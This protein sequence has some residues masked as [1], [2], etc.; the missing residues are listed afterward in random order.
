MRPLLASALFSSVLFPAIAAAAPPTA[1]RIG[2]VEYAAVSKSSIDLECSACSPSRYSFGKAY[3]DGTL[4]GTRT[5][6]RDLGSG[7]S[8]RGIDASNLYF[9]DSS[10]ALMSLD[11]STPQKAES[12]P[13]VAAAPHPFTS[14]IT[15]ASSEPFSLFAGVSGGMMEVFRKEPL[16]APVL[17]FSARTTEA[18]FFGRF[19]R[20][21]PTA[22]SPRW[23]VWSSRSLYATDGTA[24]GT[25]Q[26]ADG[27]IECDETV[28]PGERDVIACRTNGMYLVDGATRTLV[29]A[30]LYVSD[31]LTLTKVS[32]APAAGVL[33]VDRRGGA[34]V[35]GS[36]VGFDLRYSAPNGTV[37]VLASA[38]P[39]VSR[40]IVRDGR[41]F[42]VRGGNEP[43]VSDGTD[44][45]TKRDPALGVTRLTGPLGYEIVGFSGGKRI[46]LV[47]NATSTDVVASDDAGASV[48]GQLPTRAFGV[49]RRTGGGFAWTGTKLYGLSERAPELVV[50]T[51]EVPTRRLELIDDTWSSAAV[52]SLPNGAVLVSDGTAA[53]SA[54][55]SP[56]GY[57]DWANGDSSRAS[58]WR[59]GSH[60][61]F[62]A[63][64]IPAA[65][66]EEGT[67]AIPLPLVP[68]D[69]VGPGRPGDAGVDAAAPGSRDGGPEG[70]D[71]GSD[72]GPESSA[73]PPAG[74]EPSET[75]SGCSAAT[76]TPGGLASTVVVA[77]AVLGGLRRR[78][79]T[80]EG[81]GRRDA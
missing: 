35:Y 38:A 11:I 16:A 75:S 40:G 6:A 15:F 44:V 28:L 24:A 79:S 72:G 22:A 31:G 12:S 78:R 2:G 69:G 57:S 48:V 61:Y 47:S 43:W 50:D 34:Y 60:V 49:V 26:L 13:L 27:P 63:Y 7:L 21:S 5:L 68:R 39:D 41:L 71:A 18:P 51:V 70:A 32:D 9:A 59:T 45:G 54:V 17:L 3:S 66:G 30:G 81:R 20:L 74:E 76:S 1:V 37:S 62:T 55:V 77:M 8:P 65:P 67:F 52:F 56:P 46:W 19:L 58:F 23:L 10:G 29:G 73:P 33:G 42:F 64:K 14:A 36:A 4:A 80:R 25:R 53:G